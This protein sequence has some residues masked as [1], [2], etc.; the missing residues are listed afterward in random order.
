MP[1]KLLY[2]TTL[3]FDESHILHHSQEQARCLFHL[4]HSQEQARCLFH[5]K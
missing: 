3:N 4:H 2:A 1:N 5:K